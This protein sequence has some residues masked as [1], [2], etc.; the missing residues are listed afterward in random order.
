MVA[1]T[2]FDGGGDGD[3]RKDGGRQSLSPNGGCKGNAL[4]RIDIGAVSTVD[5]RRDWGTNLR[6]Q[7][8]RW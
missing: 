2:S 7:G 6:I 4:V 5:G 8:W 1:E 3:G